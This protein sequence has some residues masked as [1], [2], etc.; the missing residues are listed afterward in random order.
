MKK[1]LPILALFLASC[2]SDVGRYQAFTRGHSDGEASLWLLDTT[3]GVLYVRS[4]G[5]WSARA[6][7]PAREPRSEPR[8]LAGED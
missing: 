3:T 4:I 7:A 2:G 5:E 8:V 6:S 1:I